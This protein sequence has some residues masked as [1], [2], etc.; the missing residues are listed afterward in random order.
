MTGYV[1]AAYAIAVALVAGYALSIWLRR[2]GVAGGA[3][4]SGD[5]ADGPRGATG[6]RV[7]A[8]PA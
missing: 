3:P 4:A 5:G 2:R 6:D 7:G 1:V 8:G